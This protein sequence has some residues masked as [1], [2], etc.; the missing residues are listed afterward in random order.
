LCRLLEVSRSGYDEWLD[1]PPSANADV[2]QQLQEKVQH[3]FA[4]GRGTYGTRRIKHRLAQEGLQVSQRRIGH[5][6]AQSGLRCKTRRTFKTPSTAWRHQL[7][8]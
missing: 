5:L 2:D 3:Y 1:R 7:F 4:Q 6:L 8:G